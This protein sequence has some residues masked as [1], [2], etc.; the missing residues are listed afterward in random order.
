MDYDDIFGYCWLNYLIMKRTQLFLLLV[1]LLCSQSIYAQIDP[2]PAPPYI[3]ATDLRQVIRKKNSATEE[4]SVTPKKGKLMKF[5]VP[6]FGSNPTLGFFYGVGATGAIFLGDPE[7]TSIS[8]LNA[9]L[10]VTTKNQF[11]AAIKGTIM[12]PGNGWEMLVDLKYSFFSENTYGL[13]SDNNQLIKESWNW[14]GVTT[15][16]LGGAQPLTFN[17]TKIYYTA[18]KEVTD[19]F[20]IGIGYHLDLHYK[21]EDLSLDLEAPDTVITSHYAYN[22][23]NDISTTGYATSGLSFNLVYDSRDH[24]VNPYKGAFIQIMNRNNLDKLGSTK[25][26]NAIYME[27]R[28]YKSLSPKTPRHL[29]GFWGIANILTSGTVPYLHLPANAYDMRNRIGRGYVAGRFRGPGWVTMETEY[30]FPI[31]KNGL[32]GGVVFASAT[33]TSRDAITIGEETFPKL[34]LFESTKPAAG[35]GARIML[36]RTG[37]LNLAMDMAFGDNG[38]KGFY[39]AVGETF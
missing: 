4:E 32:F 16:G 18:L 33:T 19:N 28:L 22:T 1:G 5:I 29:L 17:Q 7:T 2:T 21:I 30:R 23:I 25:N 34:K 15:S 9:S 38:A 12:T 20:Y 11:V 6:I 39:F 35:F 24:T 31:S 13:G 14:G 37:R 36:N 3:D 10:Q 8:S 27:A 26:S